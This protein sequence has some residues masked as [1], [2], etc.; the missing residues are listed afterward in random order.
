MA[1]LLFREAKPY[2][3]CYDL[4]LW[5]QGQSVFYQ[6]MFFHKLVKSMRGLL[7]KYARK[8]A[9]T[10]QVAHAI[11]VVPLT[12]DLVRVNNENV[13]SQQSNGQSRPRMLCCKG[14]RKPLLTCQ[15]ELINHL[16]KV[17]CIKTVKTEELNVCMQSRCHIFSLNFVPILS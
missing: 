15:K 5:A 3:I 13:N 4:E 12:M 10:D 7:V 11:I 9:W 6:N 1:C 16:D 8:I 14:F 2:N 17:N